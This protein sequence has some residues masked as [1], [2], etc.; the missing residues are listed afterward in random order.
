MSYVE[1]VISNYDMGATPHADSAFRVPRWLA[2][3]H[4]QTLGAALPLHAPLGFKPREA[5]AERIV[6][7]TEAGVGLAAHAWWHSGDV[8]RR[9]AVVVHGVGGSANS[10]YV[11]R[12]AR[13][14]FSAGHHVVRLN[15][16]GAGDG[17]NDATSMYHAGLSHDLRAVVGALAELPK[18]CELV[19]VGFSLGGNVALKAA[20]EW[21]ENAPSKLRG[22]ASIS[23]PLDLAAVSK[24][25][26]RL[27]AWP[28]HKWIVEGLI[29]QARAFAAAHPTHARF[30]PRALR[31]IRTVYEYDERVV[32]PMHGFP[33][34]NEYYARASS[35]PYLADIR[36]PTL[37]IHAEDDPL[38]PMSTVRAPLARLGSTSAARSVRTRITPHGGHVGWYASLDEDGLVNNWPMRQVMSFFAN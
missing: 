30:D 10:R 37:L 7:P 33:S 36:V 16:R 23:A 38:V 18:V 29:V 31:G 26:E 5:T 20:G 21:G 15:L 27:Q 17:A 4:V 32:A 14:L 13:A 25:L 12:A 35:G 19:V 24:S 6:V 22:V 11:I 1:S 3:P 28:Y 34:A 8:A 9:L 2:S